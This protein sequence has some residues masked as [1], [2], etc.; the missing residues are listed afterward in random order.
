MNCL[1]L[2]CLHLNCLHCKELLAATD[3]V[4]HHAKMHRECLMRCVTGS[5]DC[6]RSGPHVPGTCQP[7]DPNLT[8][9]EAARRAFAA[10]KEKYE[11]QPSVEEEEWP[12]W[13]DA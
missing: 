8:K 7:D 1:H 6:I 13:I 9:R 2:N 11:G 4:I 5:E 12:D 3:D 10:W